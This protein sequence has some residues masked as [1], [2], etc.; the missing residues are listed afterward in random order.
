M[1]VWKPSTPL[2]LYNVAIQVNS[3]QYT[4]VFKNSFHPNKTSPFPHILSKMFTHTGSFSTCGAGESCKRICGDTITYAKVV[5]VSQDQSSPEPSG[6][7]CASR[8]ARRGGPGIII[9]IPCSSFV[10]TFCKIYVTNNGETC[11]G[12]HENFQ[13]PY[14]SVSYDFCCYCN[15]VFSNCKCD[16]CKCR[17]VGGA[18]NGDCRGYLCP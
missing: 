10:N 4:F 18:C 6:D 2:S 11:S 14:G 9:F 12:L 1:R 7:Y 15:K 3:E 16:C 13:T 8:T 17:Q 5:T